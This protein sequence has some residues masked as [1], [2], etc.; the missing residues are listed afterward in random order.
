MKKQNFRLGKLNESG[1]FFLG[2]ER[3]E[4]K[5]RCCGV[6]RARFAKLLHACCALKILRRSWESGAERRAT[7]QTSMQG[8]SGLGELRPKQNE[9]EVRGRVWRRDDAVRVR[10]QNYLICG[11]SVVRH[12]KILSPYL[13]L[14][15]AARNLS[16]A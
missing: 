7:T 10:N 5:E 1:T 11:Q 13:P 16:L 12:P 15:L 3:A 4:R 6:C 2:R 8:T 14:R 9:E